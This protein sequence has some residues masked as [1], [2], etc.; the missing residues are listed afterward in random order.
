MSWTLKLKMTGRYLN[1]TN[2]PKL[3]RTVRKIL[4]G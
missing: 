1:N 3:K 2:E 4:E